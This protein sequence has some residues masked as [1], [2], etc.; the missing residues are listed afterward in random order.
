[1]WSV[2][3]FGSQGGHARGH[4]NTDMRNYIRM[5]VLLSRSFHDIPLVSTAAIWVCALRVRRLGEVQIWKGGGSLVRD[6]NTVTCRPN[7]EFF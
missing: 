1:M 6:R 7:I 3:A 2:P 4:N 5:S